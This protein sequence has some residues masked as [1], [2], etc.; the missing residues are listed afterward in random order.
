MAQIYISICH[1]CYFP[2][3]LPLA[4]RIHILVAC[5]CRTLQT[6]GALTNTIIIDLISQNSFPWNN[7]LNY[8]NHLFVMYAVKRDVR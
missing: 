7:D 3:I 5:L 8:R 4:V 6:N 2:T 1:C